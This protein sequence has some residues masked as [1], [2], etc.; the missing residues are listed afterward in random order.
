M[1]S[2][3]TKIIAALIVVATTAGLVAYVQSLRASLATSE[4]NNATLNAAL[5]QQS[6]AIESMQS[7]IKNGRR[8][9]RELNAS[10]TKNNRDLRD[11]QRRLQPRQDPAGNSVGLENLAAK[12][13][14]LIERSINRG[15]DNAYRCLEIASGAP[16]TEQ[17]QNAIKPS[18]IN[19]ECPSLANPRYRP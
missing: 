1:I 5:E 6:Q 7:D 13:P 11:L 10:I 14:A 15:T 18:E 2:L 12:K 3:E 9:T 8:L 16:L 4:A 19:T 17:E